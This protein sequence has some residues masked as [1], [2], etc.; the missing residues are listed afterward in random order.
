[1]KKT[2]FEFLIVDINILNNNHC[3]SIHKTKN[4]KM[5]QKLISLISV[6]SNTSSNNTLKI[7]LPIT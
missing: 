4:L 2:V 6:I 3:S 5:N 1:M 7:N